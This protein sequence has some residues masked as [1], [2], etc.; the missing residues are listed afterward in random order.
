MQQNDAENPI[1]AATETI[2]CEEG[3]SNLS[4]KRIADKIGQSKSAIYY[5]YDSKHDLLLNFLQYLHD[6]LETLLVSLEDSDPEKQLAALTKEL[7]DIDNRRKRNLRVAIMSL[8]CEAPHDEEIAQMFTQID[9]ILYDQVNQLYKEI[10]A[11]NPGR[12][13]ALLLSA[14]DGLVN[15]AISHTRPIQV[16]DVAKTLPQRF[17]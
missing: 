7:T 17:L 4:I 12:S 2:I 15:R 6:E 14:I 9:T 13:A 16:D 3:L 8:R 11:S 1:L 10:G 5:H